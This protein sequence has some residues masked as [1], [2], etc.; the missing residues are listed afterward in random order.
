MSPCSAQDCPRESWKPLTLGSLPGLFPLPCSR[1]PDRPR[2]PRGPAFSAKCPSSVLYTQASCSQLPSTLLG[3]LGS[4]GHT[5]LAN[6]PESPLYPASFLSP[7]G[8]RLSVNRWEKRT[9][10]NIWFHVNVL[11]EAGGCTAGGL[12]SLIRGRPAGAE[13]GRGDTLLASCVAQPP[14]GA[15]SALQSHRLGPCYRYRSPQRE[16]VL[17][18][19]HPAPSFCSARH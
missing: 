11:D 2:S 4:P 9:P 16:P 7:S 3:G 6:T 17:S 15:H 10:V 19:A 14:H 18:P 8:Y 13:C 5:P 1:A 12:T